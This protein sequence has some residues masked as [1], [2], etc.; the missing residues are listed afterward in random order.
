MEFRESFWRDFGVGASRFWVVLVSGASRFWGR[1][2]SRAREKAPGSFPDDASWSPGV[3]ARARNPDAPTPKSLKT[4]S[5]Q[6]KESPKKS[7]KESTSFQEKS[8]N[9]IR[10][11]TDFVK[12]DQK[13]DQQKN[14]S[15]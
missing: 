14:L 3:L 10:S 8:K 6:S 12:F 15:K 13:Y 1:E 9:F 7:K 2:S 4:D 5:Q 11:K